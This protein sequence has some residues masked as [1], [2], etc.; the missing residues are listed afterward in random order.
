MQVMQIKQIMQV[1]HAIEVMQV[2]QIMQAMQ[3]IPVHSGGG[4]CTRTAGCGEV[5]VN[6]VNNPLRRHH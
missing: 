6:A 2:R 5:R 3:V 4:Q 1:M